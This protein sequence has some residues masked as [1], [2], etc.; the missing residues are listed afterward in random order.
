MALR[1]TLVVIQCQTCNIQVSCLFN[2]NMIPIIKYFVLVIYMYYDGHIWSL[3]MWK[4]TVRTDP[5]TLF[6]LPLIPSHCYIIIADDSYV[7]FID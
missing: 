5:A 1:H 3:G 2:I 7:L 6:I 4:Q